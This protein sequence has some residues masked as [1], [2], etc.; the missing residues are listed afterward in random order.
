MELG[1]ILNSIKSIV[2]E[3]V[4]TVEQDN[5][6]SGIGKIKHDLAL[7]GAISAYDALDASFKLP[8]P[9]DDFAKNYLIPF[10]IHETVD[11]FNLDGTFTK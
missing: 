4:Q 7:K 3:N 10:L 9:I 8:D 5:T 11:R 6:D 1:S 2:Q